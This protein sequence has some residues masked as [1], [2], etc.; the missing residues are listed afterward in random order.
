MC[1][2]EGMIGRGTRHLCEKR[3]LLRKTDKIGIFGKESFYGDKVSSIY[4]NHPAGQGIKISCS[5]TLCSETAGQSGSP[6]ALDLDDE[7]RKALVTKSLRKRN[8]ISHTKR[9]CLSVLDV[10]EPTR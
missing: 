2:P 8:H 10:G 9:L 1:S 4:T 3:V 7:V 5:A 6:F